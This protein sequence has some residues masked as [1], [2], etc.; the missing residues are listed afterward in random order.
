MAVDGM[1]MNNLCGSG[2]Y[3][4]MYWSDSMFSEISYATGADSAEM[5]Q[6]GLRIN[7]IPKEGGNQI[8][9][10]VF[11]NFT[12]DKWQAN[13]LDDNLKSRGLQSIGK[14][15][16][17]WDFNPTVGGPIMRDKLWFHFAFRNWGVNRTVAGSY[18]RSTRRG[19][20]WTTAT[21]T[22]TCSD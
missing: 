7:M 19:R 4:A 17:I 8:R 22:A 18:P 11:G 2:Q 12:N 3:S 14:I 5:G 21:S 20:V 6:G 13:N 9:G 10:S 15:Q 16:E 1:R